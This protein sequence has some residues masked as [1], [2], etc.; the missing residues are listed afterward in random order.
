MIKS[1][2]EILR[3][4]DYS[5][6]KLDSIFIQKLKKD[7]YCLIPPKKSFWNWIQASPQDIRKVI[8]K[9][10]KFE[11]IAAGSEGKE[12]FT[13]KKNKKIEPNANRIGNLLN[14]DFTMR[15]IA[16]LPEIV[17]AAYEVIKSDIKLSSILFREPIANS[18]EQEM[19]IDWYPR[20][21]KK[22]A[23]NNVVFFLYLED[24]TVM[25]GATKLVP[26][27]HKILGYPSEH[28]NPFRPHKKEIII[29]AKAGSILAVNAHTWHKGGN[30][31][32]GE[33]RGIIVIDYRKRKLK[34]LLNLNLYIKDEVKAEFND[35]EKYLFSLRKIDKQQK[36]KSFGPGDQYRKWLKRNPQHKY[37]KPTV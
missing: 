18:G 22:D 5:S 27:S 36:E 14:K 24:S 26:K 9:L 25:N 20:N 29:E 13:V 1:T 11:G 6:N 10:I 16:T 3:L 30:N 31:K 12:E 32:L 2:K 37:Q 4:K 33:K 17:W 35:V 34:Q 7:G 19:H 23:Y 28:M 15:K 21:S 8:D